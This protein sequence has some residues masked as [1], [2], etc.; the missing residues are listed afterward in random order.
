MPKEDIYKGIIFDFCLKNLYKDTLGKG[1]IE[2][3]IKTP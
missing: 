1:R 3:K 2:F